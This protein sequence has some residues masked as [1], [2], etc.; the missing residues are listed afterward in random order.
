VGHCY[1]KVG[2]VRTGSP[3]KDPKVSGIGQLSV[4]VTIHKQFSGNLVIVHA[5]ADAGKSIIHF[6]TR[7]MIG[8]GDENLHKQQQAANYRLL[9]AFGKK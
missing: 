5:I 8:M 2:D 1:R 7:D 3:V 6:T 4:T 9:H